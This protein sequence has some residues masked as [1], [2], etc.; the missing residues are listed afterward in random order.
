MSFLAMAPHFDVAL[1]RVDRELVGT[2]ERPLTGPAV[3]RCLLD[4]PMVHPV[5]S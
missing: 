1:I 5:P 2:A 4:H 3:A